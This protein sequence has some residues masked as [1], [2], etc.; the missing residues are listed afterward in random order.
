MNKLNAENPLTQ[1]SKE[2]VDYSK[3]MKSAKCGICEHF[4]PPS[5]CTEVA[6]KIEADMWCKL[7]KRK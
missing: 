7:F 2:S 6:G 5:A 4:R 1:R 3:G